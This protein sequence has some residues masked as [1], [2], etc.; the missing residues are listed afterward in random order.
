MVMNEENAGFSTLDCARVHI[1]E[2][3]RRLL[4]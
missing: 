1:E 2:I 4:A 3:T